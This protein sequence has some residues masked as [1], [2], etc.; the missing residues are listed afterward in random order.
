MNLSKVSDSYC[1]ALPSSPT[2]SRPAEER[3]DRM[4][5]R[6]VKDLTREEQ[7]RR[8]PHRVEMFFEMPT[9]MSAHYKLKN[10]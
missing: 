4:R 8:S 10:E 3:G 1:I 2:P 6:R 7:L 9:E 5:T